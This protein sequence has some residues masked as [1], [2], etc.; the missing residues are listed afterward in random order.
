MVGLALEG[1]NGVTAAVCRADL[2]AG[3]GALASKKRHG[4]AGLNATLTRRYL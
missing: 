1:K 3:P 2:I 4:R